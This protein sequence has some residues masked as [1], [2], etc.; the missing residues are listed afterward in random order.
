MPQRL[1]MTLRAVRRRRLVKGVETVPVLSTSICLEVKSQNSVPSH[2]LKI[3]NEVEAELYR[4]NY[5]FLYFTAMRSSYV[6]DLVRIEGLYRDGPLLEIG[7]FPFCFSMCLKKLGIE[8]VT[9]DLAPQRAQELIRDYS[10]RVAKCDIE[11]EPLPFRD[12]SVAA[13]TLCATL[14]HLRVDPLFALEEMRRVLQ[15]EG[16]LYL[17]SPNLYRFGNILSFAL[18]RGLAFDPIREYG[19]LRTVGHMGHVREY[20]A[21]EIHKFLAAA[22][23]GSIEVAT[24]ATPSRRGKFVDVAYRLL[25]GMRNELVVTARPLRTHPE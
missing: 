10:L 9:V 1:H 17:T 18:G 16:F 14:E 20:T 24:R 8:L 3:V 6:D 11:R 5:A 13:I 2:L 15:P 4:R 23:F 21:S 25:P 7:G 12:K 19:K 22:G